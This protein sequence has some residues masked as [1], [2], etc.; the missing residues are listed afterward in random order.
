MRSVKKG[1]EGSRPFRS[2]HQR[3][4]SA[5]TT[6]ECVGVS[7]SV[8]E[9]PGH[10]Y[11]DTT[12]TRRRKFP[13]HQHNQKQLFRK[14]PGESTRKTSPPVNPPSKQI[15]GKSAR[16]EQCNPYVHSQILTVLAL[17]GLA[18]MPRLVPLGPAKKMKA[19]RYKQLNDVDDDDDDDDGYGAWLSSRS[20][21]NE[22]TR[23][24]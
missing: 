6:K 5:A 15:N 10:R 11:T 23:E 4:R 2:G 21:T 8:T 7:V 24:S 19:Q 1:E 9:G 13:S 12:S 20:R 16:T 14:F 17:C 3:R 18:E 22:R